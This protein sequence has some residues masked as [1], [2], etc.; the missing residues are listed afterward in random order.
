MA[1]KNAGMH[2][3]EDLQKE[4]L[5]LPYRDL[6]MMNIISKLIGVIGEDPTREG[7]K[8]T[9]QR[10]SDFWD[11]FIN[12]KDDNIETTFE[13]VRDVDEIVLVPNICDWSMCEHHLLPFSVV[14]N[15][16]YIPGERVIGLSKIPRIV[17]RHCRA[18]QLQERLTEQIATTLED[19]IR[20]KGVAVVISGQHTCM[21]MRGVM[22]R[23]ASMTTSCM[24]GVFL[25]NPSARQEFMS[26]LELERRG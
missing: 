6:D 5:T 11:E 17:R 2:K 7:L 3:V 1:Q 16:G 20:P 21:Q 13:A 19:L 15:V 22:A 9:P 14:A 12:Y 18:L 24:R 23:E 25:A 4:Q 10:V 26:L 8:G